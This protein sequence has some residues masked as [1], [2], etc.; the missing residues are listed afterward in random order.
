MTFE[1]FAALRLPAI[2][3]F[4]AV[5]AGDRAQAEDV[6]QE[7]LVRV[8]ARWSRISRLDRPDAYVR[9]MVVNEFISAR[10][11]SWRLVPA[12]R[13]A[14]FDRRVSPRHAPPHPGRS[15]AGG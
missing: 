8:H 3:R 14:D 4:A 5:L 6:V 13:P 11:R 9:R 2:L 10:R 12:G 15:G 7:V 1:E